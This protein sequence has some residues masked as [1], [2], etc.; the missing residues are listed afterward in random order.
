METIVE[1]LG[2]RVWGLGLYIGRMEKK[3]E[4]AGSIGVIHRAIW[5]YIGMTEKNMETSKGFRA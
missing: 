5:G 1:V 2:F 3:M 4:T